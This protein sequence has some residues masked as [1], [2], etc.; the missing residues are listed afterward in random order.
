MTTAELEERLTR[1]EEKVAQ[2]ERTSAKPV[3]SSQKRLDKIFGIYANHPAFEEM[4]RA[5]QEWRK[6]GLVS[7]DL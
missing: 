1:L 4:V 5:G 7:E 6:T 3:P 2:M